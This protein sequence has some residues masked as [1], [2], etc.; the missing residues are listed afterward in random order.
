M[1]TSGNT[2]GNKEKGNEQNNAVIEIRISIPPLFGGS[3]GSILENFGKA[4]MEVA[5]VGRSFVSSD[6]SESPKMRK[7]EIK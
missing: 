5:K 6:S 2:Q 1:S 4:A 7:I 3:F